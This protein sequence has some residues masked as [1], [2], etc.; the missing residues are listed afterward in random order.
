MLNVSLNYFT[1]RP[2]EEDSNS[3]YDVTSFLSFGCSRRY[4]SKYSSV[5]FVYCAAQSR[6]KPGNVTWV[7]RLSSASFRGRRCYRQQVLLDHISFTEIK[8]PSL[9]TFSSI[10]IWI[11]FSI[12]EDSQIHRLYCG[13]HDLSFPQLLWLANLDEMKYSRT[14]RQYSCLSRPIC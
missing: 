7:D 6:A 4:P 13:I 11:T 10:N 9:A 5:A 12:G 3:R 14:D 1:C 2:V 8:F